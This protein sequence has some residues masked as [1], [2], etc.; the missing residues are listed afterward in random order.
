MMKQTETPH[1]LAVYSEHSVHQGQTAQQSGIP[2]DIEVRLGERVFHMLRPGG[3]ERETAVVTGQMQELQ[4]DCLPVLL[5]CGLGH[6]LR[7][8]L[9]CVDGP[10]AVVEKEA[11]LQAITGVLQSLPTNLRERITLITS[12]SHQDALTELTHWQM[13]HGGLR[14]LPLALPFYLRLDRDYYGSLQKDLLASARFDFWSRAAGPRFAGASP[15]VLL[16][17]SK[18]FL[19]GEIEGACRKLGIEYKL[20]V[21]RDE[22]V[23]RADFVQQLLEAVVAFRPDCCITLNHM[24]VDV[25]GVLMDLLARLQLPLASWFVDNPHLIIHLYSR[26]VSPWTTLFTWDADNIESLRTSGFGH[27]FYLPLGTDPDR[28][29][30]SKGAAAPAA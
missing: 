7:Q 12:P 11:G 2:D 18:Y 30:P 15:R 27:V 17:T 1:F 16:L 9:Q 26:C 25:E 6:A 5:G 20:V 29:H 3:A 10:V 23:A 8:V 24:G 28:F 19:M 21:I 4:R 13:L 22:A 14:L